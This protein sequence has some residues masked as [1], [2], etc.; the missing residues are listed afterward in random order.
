[1]ADISQPAFDLQ[2][3]YVHLEDG[4]GRSKS[5]RSNERSKFPQLRI[6]Q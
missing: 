5:A 4:R 6:R 2:T 3:T 1:M